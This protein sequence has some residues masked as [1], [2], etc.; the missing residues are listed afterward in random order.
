M[1]FLLKWS[2]FTV[3]GLLHPPAASPGGLPGGPR[4]VHGWIRGKAKGRTSRAVGRKLHRTALHTDADAGRACA[5]REHPPA[6]TTA[7][8]STPV[9]QRKRRRQRLVAGANDDDKQFVSPR[10]H[11]IVFALISLMSLGG[12]P[13]PQP[14]R[15]RWRPAGRPP[16]IQARPPPLLLAQIH[17]NP[18]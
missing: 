5:E 3:L 9:W 4:G 10:S 2:I 17:Q 16:R 8:A 13:A 11:L 1:L 14:S 7:A 6:G 18:A 12:N 15:R